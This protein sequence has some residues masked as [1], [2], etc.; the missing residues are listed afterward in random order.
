MAE[1]DEM[2]LIAVGRD[3]VDVAFLTTMTATELQTQTVKV[4][5]V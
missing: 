3:A 1:A 5:K 4:T 2:A